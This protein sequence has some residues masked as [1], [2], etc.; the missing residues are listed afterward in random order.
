[1]KEYI[2]VAIG[3]GLGG[4]MRYATSTWLQK[5]FENSFPIGT[6][7]V[8]II[9]CLLIGLIG[10]IAAK[11]GISAE[12]KLLLTVG[13]CGGFTTFSTFINENMQLLKSDNLLYFSIYTI[14]SFALGLAAVWA[15]NEIGK[16]I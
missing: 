1:M 14:C 16:T 7:A 12:T 6:M 9:G 13:M 5:H 2:L 15:G 10:S 8:N 4:M 3:S 11:G